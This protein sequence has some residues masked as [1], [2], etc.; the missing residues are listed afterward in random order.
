MCLLFAFI[1]PLPCDSEF[2]TLTTICGKKYVSSFFLFECFVSFLV[3]SYSSVC[4]KK[5]SI[6]FFFINILTCATSYFMAVYH[7]PS[8]GV[9]FTGQGVLWYLV[10]RLLFCEFF[11]IILPRDVELNYCMII[12]VSVG[13]VF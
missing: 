3:L 8:A 1:W 10:P 2:Q 7:I 6:I 11:W 4:Y 5:Q 9:S 13:F 12:I